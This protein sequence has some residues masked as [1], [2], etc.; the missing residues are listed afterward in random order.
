MTAEA[1]LGSPGIGLDVGLQQP[2]AYEA[3]ASSFG[4]D[5]TLDGGESSSSLAP[6][7]MSSMCPLDTTRTFS[8]FSYF[9]F[10]N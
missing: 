4:K 7:M 3:E 1:S 5:A 8:V 9:R 2:F 6:Q 10:I